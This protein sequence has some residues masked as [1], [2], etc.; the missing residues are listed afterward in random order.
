M[1]LDILVSTCLLCC[2]QDSSLSVIN[3]KNLVLT[4]DLFKSFFFDFNFKVV[5]FLLVPV[6]KNNKASFANI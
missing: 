4:V 6:L 1:I 2:F 5:R 3:P